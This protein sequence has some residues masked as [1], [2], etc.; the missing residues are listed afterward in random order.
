MEQQ[1][2]RAGVEQFSNG[3]FIGLRMYGYRGAGGGGDSQRTVEEQRQEVVFPAV[4]AGAL[5]YLCIDMDVH[6]EMGG[7]GGPQVVCGVHDGAAS[8][9]NCGYYGVS[10]YG[11]R[12]GA[13]CHGT[14]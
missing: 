7:Q 11:D 4:S 8:L 10:S 13:D 9:C 6:G 14:F 2:V 3:V 12:I 5:L 1:T